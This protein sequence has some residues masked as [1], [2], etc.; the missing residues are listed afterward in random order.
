MTMENK[1]EKLE[2]A[3][4]RMKKRRDRM[5][6][7]ETEEFTRKSKERMKNLRQKYPL[8]KNETIPSSYERE[9][10]MQKLRV[11]KFREN[12][13]QEK[14]MLE[15]EERN[16]RM[17]KLREKQSAEEKKLEDKKAKE[18]M[19]KLRED[20]KKLCE[21]S[22]SSS[23]SSLPEDQDI[24]R[25]LNENYRNEK[26]IHMAA[27][28]ID[29]L[30]EECVCD[31]DIDCNYCKKVNEREKNLQEIITMEVKQQYAMEDIE[32]F[33]KML[34]NKR[35]AKRMEINEKL[36]KPIKPFP[37]KE[38]SKYE[39]IREDIIKQRKKEWLVFEKE[40]EKKW[41]EKRKEKNMV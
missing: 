30:D 40:W 29:E 18:R 19:R 16:K 38:M 5:T 17:R 7:S 27:R 23:E 15:K 20:R 13:S 41:E 26:Q 4:E 21:P 28:N 3:K 8:K 14:K 35:K 39:K 2:K 9:K 10:E 36:K 11:R 31:I 22:D 24:V 12:Q 1:I 6:S 25:K 34:K 33:K 37:V 32:Q